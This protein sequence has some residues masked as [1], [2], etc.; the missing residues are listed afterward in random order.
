[1]QGMEPMEMPPMSDPTPETPIL[2][3]CDGQRLLGI[4]TQPTT[5]ENV[6]VL[7]IVGGPQYRA[8]SHRQFTLLARTLAKRGIPSFR[9]D[10]RGMGDSEGDLRYFENI[11]DD[12]RAAIN[13]FQIQC[14]YVSQIVLWGLC[15]AASAAMYYAP[16]DA[17]V[18]A[19]ILLNPWVHTEHGAAR[20]RLKNYYLSRLFQKS[21]WIKL[22]TGGIKLSKTMNELTQTAKAAKTNMVTDQSTS[23]DAR[24]G[25]DGF[26]ERMLSGLQSFKGSTLIILSSDDYVAHEFVALS[27]SNTS[28]TKA[29]KSKNI[30]ITRVDN[31]NHTFSSSDL[32]KKVEELTIGTAWTLLQLTKPV[33][34]RRHH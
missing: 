1:M 20:V 13:Q 12:I 9:F 15:D 27:A 16:N 10:Y 21:F 33:T 34:D 26:I 8:G 23:K 5:P 18:I 30:T 24:H 17:R 14:P 6:G 25:N 22:L 31:S 3:T 32:R 28:W 4:A 2:F 29:L 11:D 7:I 19:Q